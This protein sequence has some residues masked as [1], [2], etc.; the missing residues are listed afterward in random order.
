MAVDLAKK[1]RCIFTLIC[2][3]VLGLSG[4]VAQTL[5][6]ELVESIAKPAP[7]SPTNLANL[8]NVPISNK[9]QTEGICWVTIPAGTF[10]MGSHVPAE[11][12]AKD[13]VEYGRAPEYFADEFPQHRVEITKPFLMADTEVTV[14]QFRQ[15]VTET[16]YQTEAESDG[17]G[18]W[19]YDKELGK[20]LGRDKRFSWRDAGYP[21]TDN[22]PVVNVTWND[23]QKYCQWLSNKIGRLVRLPTEAEWEYACRAGTVGY[24]WMGDKKESLLEGAR[25][26]K[27]DENSIRHAVQDLVIAADNAVTFPV[28]VR[29]YAKNPFGLYDMHGNAWEWT[30][31]WH[32]DTYY[33]R[34]PTKDPQGPIQ[35]EVR[36]RRGGAWN[37]FPLWA[38]ASFRNWNTPDSRCVN[39]G[40]RL[41]AD[42]SSLEISQHKLA[43]PV[44]LLF[45]GDIMLDGGPGHCIQGGKDPFEHVSQMLE[46]AD[47][48]IGN[49]ECVLGREGEQ[50]LKTFNFRAALNS[51]QYLRRHFDA[52]SIAN[53]HICD[54]GIEGML[55]CIKILKQNNIGYFGAGAD[56]WSARRGLMLDCKG[57]RIQLLGYNGFNRESFQATDDSPGIAPLYEQMV[58]DDIRYAKEQRKADI[59]IPFVHWGRELVSSPQDWQR[60][61]AQKMIDA[62]ANAVIGS[63][64]HVTQTIDYYKRAPIVYSL[65]NFVFDYFPIDPPQWTGWAVR[66]DIQADSTTD[67]KVLSVELDPI[68]LPHHSER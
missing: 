21:Q 5:A 46:D 43:Q 52:L 30:A 37:T 4:P 35:G 7:S 3:F 57:R 49:L 2:L 31:D 28:P 55:E 42:L 14:G 51:E 29:S 64:P 15:F 44:R 58:L 47:V 12:I 10:L 11:Q 50:I 8:Q 39:L 34:S 25:T 61:L 65:G 66:L 62:G 20:C 40:F 6:Q 19:G 68:G 53:N 48:T 16:N 13:Y 59:V 60:D 36:V 26:L 17:D 27:P 9:M 32:D 22:Y 18:G 56:L 33:A 41:V 38:R 24:Y 1:S 54:Y 67:T 63:H 45:V 23:C